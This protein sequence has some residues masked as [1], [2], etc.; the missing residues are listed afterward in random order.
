[1]VFLHPNPTE[2]TVAIN[3][4]PPQH[5]KEWVESPPGCLWCPHLSQW[6]VSVEAEWGDVASSLLGS[7][8]YYLENW[9]PTPPGGDELPLPLLTGWYQ[10]MHIGEDAHWKGCT[11]IFP[12]LSCSKAIPLPGQWGHMGSPAE[13]PP[14]SHRQGGSYVDLEESLNS[15]PAQQG[16]HPTGLSL[17]PGRKEVEAPFTNWSNVKQGLA[18]HKI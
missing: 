6:V 3:W 4:T 14:P 11:E 5:C 15:H 7:Q 9:A 16:S 8:W 17:L 1:M 12:L 10:R 13:A 18:K 2:E